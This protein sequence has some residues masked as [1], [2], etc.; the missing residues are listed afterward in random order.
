VGKFLKLVNLEY[1]SLD[2]N[3]LKVHKNSNKTTLAYHLFKGQAKVTIV[4]TFYTT[5]W[6]VVIDSN[7]GFESTILGT[8]DPM[9]SVTLSTSKEMFEFINKHK[10]SGDIDFYIDDFYDLLYVFLTSIDILQVDAEQNHDDVETKV[11]IKFNIKNENNSVV[12]KLINSLK[13]LKK[14]EIKK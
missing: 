12:K 5:G 10:K 9:T 4:F 6:T 1:E 8:I 14:M 3:V 7:T 2:G 13:S 11:S